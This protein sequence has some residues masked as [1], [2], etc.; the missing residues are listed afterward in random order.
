MVFL[1]RDDEGGRRVNGE[2]VYLRHPELR[3]FPAWADVRGRSRAFLEPWEPTWPANELTR[4]A[5]KDKLR[6]YGD[7]I[8]ADR[9]YP[10]Y[11]FRAEDDA[12]VGGATLSRIHRGSAQSCTLGYWVGEP[13]K[14]R[15]YTRAAVRALIGFAFGDLR[16]HRI[17][18][19]CQPDNGPSRA[20]LLGV[21]FEEEGRARAYLK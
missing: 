3:D 17:E 10:F 6:R 2:G 20:L 8:Q 19:A 13:Y 14:R 12:L 1:R 15:G 4:S 5:F 18:A 21:G 9:S 16:L 11:I 7:D